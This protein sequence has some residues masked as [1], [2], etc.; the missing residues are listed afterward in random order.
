MDD[1]SHNRTPNAEPAGPTTC[2]FDAGDAGIRTTSDATTPAMFCR[3]CG[4]NLRGLPGNRCAECGRTFD[5][6]NRKSY[7][8]HSG[9]PSRRRWARGIVASLIAFFL[10][11]GAGAF[12]LWWPWHRDAA[13]IRMVHRYGG[14]VD[15]TTDGPKWLQW[16]LGQRGGFLLERA[17][18]ACSLACS[19]VTDADLSGLKG[20]EGLRVL[21]L[22]A[23][24]VTDAG[25]ERL[26]DLK[27]LRE[28]YLGRTHVTDAGLKNLT[29][30]KG[31]QVLNLSATQVTDVERLKDL[32]GLQELDLGATRVTDAGLE[33]LAD[34]KGLRVLDLGATNVTDAGLEHLTD[35]KGLR[36]LYLQHTQVTGAGLEQLKDLKGLQE[37]Y[38]EQTRVTDAG[39]EHLKDLK[40]LQVLDLGGTKATDAGIMALKRA[41][42]GC[43]IFRPVPSSPPFPT[44]D[45]YPLPLSP[46]P[47]QPISGEPHPGRK[48]NDRTRNLN[49]SPPR[50]MLRTRRTTASGP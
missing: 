6:K 36:K 3:H 17:G 35:L 41:L 47:F 11:A 40:G 44:P 4:Y 28:L 18:P 21:K 15:T 10:L 1:R 22:S 32:K 42:P 34:L 8:A 37:L 2:V 7:S 46:F 23:T 25:L 48:A 45:T 27:G 9:S 20:L 43:D 5:P 13:A 12:S 14:T 38:L 39:L 49:R 29:A 16:V 31:L 30:L 50:R 19:T 33:H 24:Q 26:K